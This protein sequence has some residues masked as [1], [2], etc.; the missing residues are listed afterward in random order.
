[1][2]V[3]H[4][5]KPTLGHIAL[6][7][8]RP[9][10][11]QRVYNDKRE[12]GLSARTIRYLHTILHSALKQAM[13]N[14]L[15][16][17]NVSEATTLPGGKTRK[18]RPLNLEQMRQFLAA[19][20]DDRLFAA[21]FLELGTGLR[22]GEILGVRWQD[23]DLEASVLHVRQTLVRVRNHDAAAGD[24]KTRLIFQE[25]KTTQSRRTIPIP[26]DIVEA[27]RHHRARQAEERLLMGE[28]YSDHGLVFCQATGQPIDPRNFT[29]HFE[30][31][32]KQA[33]LPHI[34][35]HD[36]RHTFA[37]VMLE[38]GEAPKVVQTMLGHTKIAT[39]LDIYSH[40]SLDMER[41]AAAKLNAVMR[42]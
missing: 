8:L 15:V 41:K 1:M 38:L 25:P 32:L 21:F 3:R 2:M 18:M 6:K 31:L 17:R 23:L 22:R 29:R 12:T 26:D 16:V 13:K 34:R 33:G 19:V 36:G 37:T 30:R 39:T 7:D 42:G 9:D 20:R 14:Q 11:V 24:R 5:L 28:A 4:H 27:L 10:Q 35:F 40:M